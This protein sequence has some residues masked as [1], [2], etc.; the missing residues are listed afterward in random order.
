M[1]NKKGFTIAEVLV[2][3]SLITIIL[4]S[5]I[6]STIY[7]RDKLKQ[8]E[9]VSQLTDFKNTVTKA[10]YDDITAGRI[11]GVERCIGT[12]NCINFVD[13]LGN[14]KTLKIVEVDRTTA[15]EKRGVYL[16]YAGTR[17]MLPDSDLG[18]GDNR[19]CDF[20]GGFEVSEYNNRLFKVKT[21]F[22]HK[23]IDVQFN[24]LFVVS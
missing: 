10:V 24:L 19:I 15:S 16:Y 13:G 23:D 7:Y 20:F 22:K 12:A 4:A 8:E 14:S 5:I 11:V 9:V 21:S 6:S 1:L 17:Y 3:F 18:T 2:S